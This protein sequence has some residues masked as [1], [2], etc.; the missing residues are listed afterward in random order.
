M[1]LKGKIKVKI[2]LMIDSRE[3]EDK[4]TIFLCRDSVDH[5]SQKGKRRINR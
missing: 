5:E 1:T 4:R 3:V 2:N